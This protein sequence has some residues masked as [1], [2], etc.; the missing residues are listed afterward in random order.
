MTS[1]SYP[2]VCVSGVFG[3]L[4]GGFGLSRGVP[5]FCMVFL[6]C[7]VSAL[8]CAVWQVNVFLHTLIHHRS[9]PT[10]PPPHIYHHPPPQ[11]RST[12]AAAATRASA[13]VLEVLLDARSATDPQLVYRRMRRALRAARGRVR[14]V[15]LD[16]IASFPP[17]HFEV[18]RL[19][20]LCHKHGALV[21]G[22]GWWG[23]MGCG[24]VVLMLVGGVADDGVVYTGYC[25]G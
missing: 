23:G 16:H 18:K 19:A 12:L 6:L 14:L 15:V 9:S 1:L 20:A 5:G 11:V 17:I 21:C 13:G 3:V 7:G 2:A 24:G 4:R 8:F 25:K 10:T 22:V